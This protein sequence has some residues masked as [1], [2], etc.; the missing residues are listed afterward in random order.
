MTV[1]SGDRNQ[2][3]NYLL[4]LY[5]LMISFDSAV[6]RNLWDDSK[7][8]WKVVSTNSSFSR[9]GSILHFKDKFTSAKF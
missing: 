6:H 5:K 4:E 1:K 8:A 2:P 9:T 3:G 7:P